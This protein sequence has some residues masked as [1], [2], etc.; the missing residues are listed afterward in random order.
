MAAKAGLND[1]EAYRFFR[2]NAIDLYKL[3]EYF[4]IPE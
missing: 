1:H 3:G 2:G 4:A